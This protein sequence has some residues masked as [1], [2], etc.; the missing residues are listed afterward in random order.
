M[1]LGSRTSWHRNN[2]NAEGQARETGNRPLVRRQ[3]TTLHPRTEAES[4]LIVR[5]V[6]CKK[7]NEHCRISSPFNALIGLQRRQ[8]QIQDATCNIQAA[9]CLTSLL[10]EPTTPAC[11]AALPWLRA[12]PTCCLNPQP[13]PALQH[14]L[15]SVPH[16]RHE[17][18][19]IRKAI[20]LGR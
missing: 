18:Q 15:G 11:V 9:C 3:R 4:I 2:K 5:Q 19:Q 6:E 13:L 1:S 20:Q 16:L 14:C 8:K 17:P 10:P 7:V 12:S